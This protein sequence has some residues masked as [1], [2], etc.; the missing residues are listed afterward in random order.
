MQLNYR[1]QLVVLC[2]KSMQ[3]KLIFQ[4]IALI[5]SENEFCLLL[6][7]A[8]IVMKIASG[9]S[10]FR[11]QFYISRLDIYISKLKI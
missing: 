1:P 5:F 2:R 3:L 9:F 11:I 4:E 8:E 10:G 7:K 6:I